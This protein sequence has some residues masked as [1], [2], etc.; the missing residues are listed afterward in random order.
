MKSRRVQDIIPV[1]AALLLA[2]CG[3]VSNRTPLDAAAL[4]KASQY[5]QLGMSKKR[6]ALLVK[7]GFTKGWPAKSRV[8]EEDF[9]GEVWLGKPVYEFHP[10]KVLW[11]NCDLSLSQSTD[12]T[13]EMIQIS[14]S[15]KN[16]LYVKPGFLFSAN[17]SRGESNVEY[18]SLNCEF[19]KAQGASGVNL[20][21]FVAAIE[22]LRGKLKAAE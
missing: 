11:S 10:V 14:V 17:T 5:S 6:A 3:T 18:G 19:E 9:G 12:G 1:I 22:T 20:E 13:K 8:T 21:D 7:Q 2:G 16:A 15:G 4:A